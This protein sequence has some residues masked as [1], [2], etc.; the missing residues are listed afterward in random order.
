MSAQV[1][2]GHNKEV[3]IITIILSVL[4]DIY[5]KA[6]VEKKCH[7]MKICPNCTTQD[8]KILMCGK[9][10]QGGNVWMCVLL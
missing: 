4:S 6:R 3:L 8:T 10:I 5:V 1:G 9:A 7:M 2:G